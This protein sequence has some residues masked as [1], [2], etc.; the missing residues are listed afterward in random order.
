MMTQLVVLPP[1]RCLLRRFSN[2]SQHHFRYCLCLLKSGTCTQCYQ[3][4]GL[5]TRLGYFWLPRRGQQ[6]LTATSLLLGYFW[7]PGREMS[8][9]RASLWKIVNFLSIR[10][11]FEPFQRHW[12]DLSSIDGIK[13]S[14]GV[15]E[16]DYP[17]LPELDNLS[18]FRPIGW[19]LVNLPHKNAQN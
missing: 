5:G 16:G 19:F 7:L 3:T 12:A 13:T 17:Q 9:Y 8:W 14:Y 6:S 2:L 18:C 1:C 10:G 11:D 4:R 15:I